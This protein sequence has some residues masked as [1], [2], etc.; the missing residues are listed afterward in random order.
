M[1]HVFVILSFTFKTIPEFSRQDPLQDRTLSEQD[2]SFQALEI[3]QEVA[4]NTEICIHAL[5]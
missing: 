2:H 1:K 4:K 3:T 5:V